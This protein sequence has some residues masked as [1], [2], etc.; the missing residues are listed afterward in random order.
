MTMIAYK[1][2]VD[3]VL[4]R[5]RSLYER[6][7]GDRIFAAMEVPSAALAE[8]QQQY[9]E[10]YCDYPDPAARI[11]FWDRL[12]GERAAVEDDSVPVAYL[13]EFDQ[14]LY[15]GLLGGDVQFMAHP[16]NGWIS[17][18]VAPLLDDWSQFDS[19]AFDIRHELRTRAADVPLVVHVDFEPFTQRLDEHDLP[20]GIFYKV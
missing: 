20:G 3:E 18:M 6:R 5:L 10:G 11:D 13:S 2:G 16:E 17:S 15:G 4:D 8:F 7:A 9:A 14:G 1:P 19:L 12:F